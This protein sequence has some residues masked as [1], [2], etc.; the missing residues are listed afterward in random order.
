M[1]TITV[2]FD[3]GPK[4]LGSGGQIPIFP[5]RYYTVDMYLNILLWKFFYYAHVE[6][7]LLNIII[8]SCSHYLHEHYPLL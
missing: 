3:Y 8:C 5:G 1:I 2:L 7:L 4:L 6:L